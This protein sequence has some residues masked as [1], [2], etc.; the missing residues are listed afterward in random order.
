MVSK[1]TDDD[2]EA[3]SELSLVSRNS[4]LADAG[5]FLDDVEPVV[6]SGAAI[7]GTPEQ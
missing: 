6:F 1:N 3:A 4:V 2:E 7:A 5:A